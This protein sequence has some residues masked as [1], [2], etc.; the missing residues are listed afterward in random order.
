VGIKLE[1]GMRDFV[2][3]LIQGGMPP[4]EKWDDDEREMWGRLL[5]CG[6]VTRSG[7]LEP[8]LYELAIVENLLRVGITV[9]VD[10][11]EPV[12]A[13]YGASVGSGAVF[14]TDPLR[15]GVAFGLALGRLVLKHERVG[16]YVVVAR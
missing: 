16:D 3:T 1:R 4:L 8:R 2:V 5:K 12:L 10:T 6:L 11:G 14:I 7:E 13:V 9:K 15:A